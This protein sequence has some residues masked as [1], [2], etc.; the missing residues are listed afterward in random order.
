VACPLQPRGGR[1]AI[2]RLFLLL[3]LQES[4]TM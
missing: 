4:S 1:R 2:R 3:L